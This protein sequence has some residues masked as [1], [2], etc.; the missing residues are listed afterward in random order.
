MIV[1]RAFRV[2]DAIVVRRHGLSDRALDAR[3]SCKANPGYFCCTDDQTV[4]CPN[5]A[6]CQI[7]GPGIPP[8]C[9]VRPS[10][11]NDKPNLLTYTLAGLIPSI[12]ICLICYCVFLCRRRYKRN[13]STAINANVVQ[14]NLRK[15]QRL[16]RAFANGPPPPPSYE[17][18]VLGPQEP[19]RENADRIAQVMLTEKMDHPEV[20]GSSVG[21]VAQAAA[22][23]GHGGASSS[24]S[25]DLIGE[26]RG[27][28]MYEANVIVEPVPPAPIPVAVSIAPAVVAAAPRPLIAIAADPAPAPALEK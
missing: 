28:P 17:M 1:S 3:D 13:T 2:V 8:K 23:A 25:G 24:S 20:A 18:G 16:K 12:I 6:V 10:D 15:E 9:A 11:P 27:L 5:D 4:I 14:Y 21:E 22:L 26:G 19:V 7:S